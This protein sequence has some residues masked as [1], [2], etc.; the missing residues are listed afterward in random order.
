MSTEIA[1]ATLAHDATQFLAFKRAMG[2]S[3][4]HAGFVLNSFVRFVRDRYGDHSPEGGTSGV[5]NVIETKVVGGQLAG[6]MRG[7][8]CMFAVTPASC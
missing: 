5:C 3:Y 1:A 6:S 2:T 4:R 8:I 7:S